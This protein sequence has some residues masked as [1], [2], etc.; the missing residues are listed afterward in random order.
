M[1]KSAR[2]G[3]A[4]ALLGAALLACAPGALAEQVEYTGTAVTSGMLGNTAFTN[5][6][7]TISFFSDTRFVQ[8]FVFSNAALVKGQGCD[9]P[10]HTVVYLACGFIN[11]VGTAIVTVKLGDETVTATFDPAA[12]IFVSFDVQ[13]GGIGFGRYY[14]G[15]PVPVYPLAFKNGNILGVSDVIYNQATGYSTGL[16]S[17]VT[18]LKQPTHLSGDALSC[19]NPIGNCTDPLSLPGELVLPT[20]HG[21][22][23]LTDPYLDKT[24]KIV[25]EGLFAVNLRRRFDHRNDRDHD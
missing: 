16:A 10:P 5:A 15:N 23:Y 12:K 14:Q 25:N 1:K 17:L 19:D 7:V 21:T 6:P 11:D 20:D 2:D 4:V 9:P 22:F 18:N 3:A 24:G 13:N 8:P